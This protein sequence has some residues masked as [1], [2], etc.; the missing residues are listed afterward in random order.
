M[1]SHSKEK[2]RLYRWDYGEPKLVDDPIHFVRGVPKLRPLFPISGEGENCVES[3]FSNSLWNN[4]P[5]D[6]EA[7]FVCQ[8]VIHLISEVPKASRDHFYNI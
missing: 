1:Y 6:K 7:P 4:V 8:K 5:C 2:P 3:R